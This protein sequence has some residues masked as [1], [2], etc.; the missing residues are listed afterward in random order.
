VIWQV[1]GGSTWQ[2]RGWCKDAQFCQFEHASAQIG[3]IEDGG[4]LTRAE[5]PGFANSSSKTRG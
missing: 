3:R 4:W 5:S 2:K 1:Q